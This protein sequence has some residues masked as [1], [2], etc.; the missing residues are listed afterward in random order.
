FGLSDHH[1]LYKKLEWEFA[2]LKA[3]P[4]NPYL[5]FNFFVTAWHLLEWKYPDLGGKAM[6][7]QVRNHEP[8]VQICHHLAIGAKHFIPSDPIHKSVTGTGLSAPKGL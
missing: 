7:K 6:R 2:N 1:D 3:E 8:L 4:R 5:A